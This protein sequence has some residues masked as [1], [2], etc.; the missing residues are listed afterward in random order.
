MEKHPKA[1]WS[2]TITYAL[3]IFYLSSIQIT[4]PVALKIPFIT[5]IEH[6]VEYAILGVLLLTSFRSIK[7]D[8]VWVVIALACLYGVSDEIHQ[9][10]TPGRFF[11]IHDILADC[12]GAVMGVFMGRYERDRI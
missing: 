7:K 1:I 8:G 2:V 5:T 10:F 12:I 6:I 3:L 4:Q 11:D 9:L